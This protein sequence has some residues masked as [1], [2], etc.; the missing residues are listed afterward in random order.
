MAK[1]QSAWKQGRRT[2][3][4][5]LLPLALIAAGA[6]VAGALLQRTGLAG[7]GGGPDPA[8]AALRFS[9][10]QN[11]N[12]LT[13]TTA[14]GDMPSWIEIENTGAQPVSLHGIGLARDDKVNKVFVFPDVS[15]GAG[16]FLLVY[17]D[18]TARAGLTGELHAPFRLPSAGGQKLYL[19][20]NAQNIL[21]SVEVPRME[22]D[23]SYCRGA[24]GAWSVSVQATPGA[25]N[26]VVAARGLNVKAGDVEISEAA[27]DNRTVFPDEIGECGDYL[28]LHNRA[29]HDV[30]LGGYWLSDNAAKP[31]KWVFPDVVLPA[32]GWLAVHCTGLDRR[33][34][35]AHLHTNFKLSP[36]ETVFL[37]DDTGAIVSTVALPETLVSGQALSLADG[38]WVTNIGPTPNMENTREAVLQLDAQLRAQRGSNV[39]ISEVMAMPETEQ[40]DWVELH[41]AGGE[42][43]D[44]GG[45]GLS[46][47]PDKPRKWQFPQGT[48]IG[49]G[50]YLAVFLTGAGGGSAGNYLTAP[51]AVS[52]AGGCTLSLT[53]AAGGVMDSLYMPEQYSGVS[54]GRSDAGGCGYLPAPTPLAANGGQLVL[55]RAPAPE[56]SVR[57]GLYNSGD[58]FEVTMSAAPGARI[59]YTLDCTDP[60]EGSQ[61]YDGTPIPVS[62]N[63]VLRT[64]VYQDGWLPS[65]ADAQS[66]LFD[67]RGVS[68][69]PYVVSLVSDPDG[70]YSDERGIMVKGLHPYAKFPFG[71]YGHGANFWMDW[72]REAHLEL[73]TN[74][75]ETAVSQECSIKLHGRNTRAY[76]LKSFKVKADAKYGANRFRYPIFH[77]RP[78]DEYEAFVLRYSGQD[79]KYT[80]MRDVVLTSLA[81]NTS[82]M[83][84]EA[85]ECICYLNG[86]YYS[87][88]YIR[89]N[90]SPF[91]LARREGWDESA[92]DSMDLIKAGKQVMRGSNSNYVK[93]VDW[94][95]SHDTA[96]DEAYQVIDK[97]VDI[98]NFLEYCALQ[99]F[100]GTPDSINMKRY[101]SAQTDGKW[102][103]VLYDVD[104][105]MR[106]NI[107]G[108]KILAQGT[109][110]V[111]FKAC[112]DNPKTRARFLEILDDALSSYLTVDNVT[113]EVDAQFQRSNAM[114]PQY[115]EMMGISKHE[116]ESR[117][118]TLKTLI[119][120]R[121]KQVLKQCMSYLDLSQ[122][123]L[124]QALP[125]T[126]AYMTGGVVPEAG[127]EGDEAEGDSAG[128]TYDDGDDVVDAA[129]DG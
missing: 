44:L 7:L 47:R 49:P 53:A 110:S 112:M 70:L 86:E 61:L 15:L 38:E 18:G 102:R 62:S 40:Y 99:I 96:S 95:K 1:K 52:S 57:G 50:E 10:I 109:N 91:S 93:L 107:N 41:N 56:Y 28:E 103:F 58:A 108:F 104:R 118:R 63:T 55:G 127:G 35:P 48:S 72:E 34:D 3:R 42:A 98:D 64:K 121:P 82:V 11:N 92:A 77:D 32:G 25:A 66:Y 124:V 81:R 113:K 67:V 69:T 9:E 111:L 101:R 60:G 33:D 125:R 74:S 14:D 129:A 116:Y 27:A 78:Y 29:G 5:A 20:D 36:G 46:D 97:C 85:E 17:A 122:E 43:V 71:N 65:Y 2:P 23:E 39:Y 115:L 19:F 100:I 114:L 51:F 73:F 120:R 54:F 75:G 117:L 12:A 123:Q 89:E 126:Y 119:K 59:Y 128:D 90:V 22:S 31:G 84:M 79:Y 87:A 21:D 30:R 88:M 8:T 37:A 94:L 45:C 16:E 105:G 68:G 13:L 4:P 76:V 80:V 6:I 26:D 83:Y 106:E 24:D